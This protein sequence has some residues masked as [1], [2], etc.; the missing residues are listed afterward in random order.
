[1]IWCNLRFLNNFF[2]YCFIYINIFKFKDSSKIFCISALV[3]LQFRC[4]VSVLNRLEKFY[5]QSLLST[6]TSSKVFTA[7]C[8][9]DMLN[10]S[11]GVCLTKYIKKQGLFSGSCGEIKKN[12]C[13]VT[14]VTHTYLDLT[15]VSSV[16]PWARQIGGKHGIFQA[17][18]SLRV[19]R[20]WSVMETGN[21]TSM[22]PL[23]QSV[24]A[25]QAVYA[26]T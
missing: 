11:F 24:D 13:R 4:K 25:L 21:K 8:R 17:V 2:C 7:T 14:F 23:H 16:W 18:G 9:R 6:E 5:Y 15:N 22:V 10:A 12:K 1:M 26:A 19:A 20:D 3:S